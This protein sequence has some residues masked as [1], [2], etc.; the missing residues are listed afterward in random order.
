V[1]IVGGGCSG[2]FVAAQLSLNGF[3]G[4][5]RIIEPRALLGRGL[6]Y[7]TNFPEH[8]LNVPAEKMSAFPDVPS[9]FLD[10]LRAR[11]PNV[12]QRGFFAP[13]MLY[14]EY[15]GGLLANSP[16]GFAHIRSEVTRIERAVS[17]FT[18][19]LSFGDSLHAATVVLALGDNA[20][21]VRFPGERILLI[22]TGLTAVE[23]VLALQ[24]QSLPCELHLV[25]RR[26]ILPCAHTGSCISPPPHFVPEHD[27][28][29]LVR[30]LRNRVAC[31][32]E[33]GLCWRTVVDS[34]RSVSNIIWS[35]LSAADRARF[36][37]HLK[38]YWE[39]HRHRM[40]PQVRQRLDQLLREEKV[41]VMSGRIGEIS[42]A[43]NE[44]RCNVHLRGGGE[45][46]LLVDRVIN[47]S[48]I[49]ERYRGAPVRPLIQSLVAGGIAE[50]NALGIGFRTDPDGALLTSNIVAGSSVF[51]LG[52][53]LVASCSRPPRCPRFARRRRRFASCRLCTAAEPA[54]DE[55]PHGIALRFE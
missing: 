49:Q 5:L 48:G 14:G 18:L 8:L 42:V 25:W 23:A 22:G 50:P 13:R 32:Q 47:C 46:T 43:E 38:P 29:R 20:L 30:Q 39:P 54:H 31:M 12:P 55:S 16:S 15:L 24:G 44:L 36:F 3:A 2:V 19:T 34:L 6:A 27:L 52:P 33:R 21:T 10:W 41:Q 11:I 51:T 45:V 53:P 4:R 7:S 40:A 28:R 26:G 1:A 35:E 17:S 37:R 9:H